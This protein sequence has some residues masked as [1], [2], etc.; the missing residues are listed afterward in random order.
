MLIKQ[1]TV[2]AVSLSGDMDQNLV[3]AIIPIDK[4][5]QLQHLRLENFH[6]YVD[7]YKTRQTT[8]SFLASLIGV[9][10]S[11]QSLEVIHSRG[12]SFGSNF[13]SF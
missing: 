12:R 1:R 7:M 9:C 4:A 6:M 13:H 10:T 8:R 11:M 2:N 3:H 5:G